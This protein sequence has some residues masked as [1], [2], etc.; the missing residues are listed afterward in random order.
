MVRPYSLDLRERVVDAVGKGP[1]C[2]SVARIFGVSVASVVKWAQRLRATGRAAAK[3]MGGKCPYALAGERDWLLARITAVPDITLRALAAELAERGIVVSHYAVWH[4]LARDG[5]TFKKSLH[6]S[7][8]DRPDVAR[9]RAQRKKYQARLDPTRLVFIDE[10]WAKTNM[11]RRHG[12][13]PRGQRLLAKV[14]HG[15]WRTSPSSPPCAM[16]RSP[17]HASSTARSTARASLPMS[18][19]SCCLPCA[20]ATSSSWTTWEATKAKP[21]GTPS[22]RPVPSSSSCRNTRPT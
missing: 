15:R 14:P 16:T 13:C 4:I 11:T 22:D 12:R 10:T 17:R 2:R 5:I 21:S 1:S 9:R 7:E 3:P 8:Q 19:R 20:A 18:S 6:A